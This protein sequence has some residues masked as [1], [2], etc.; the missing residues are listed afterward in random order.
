MDLA[1]VTSSAD[2]LGWVLRPAIKRE[3]SLVHI[4]E[5]PWTLR[6]NLA[7]RN[8]LN[9]IL[10]ISLGWVRVGKLYSRVILT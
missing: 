1:E 2:S 9:Y 7:L 4:I 8:I 6:L 5:N 3:D 10:Q